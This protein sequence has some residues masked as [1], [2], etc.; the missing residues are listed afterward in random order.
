[1]CVCAWVGGWAGCEK[2]EMKLK[3]GGKQKMRRRCAW[4]DGVSVYYLKVIFFLRRDECHDVHKFCMERKRKNRT[5]FPSLYVH[6]TDE[7]Q[8]VFFDSIL[9][10]VLTRFHPPDSIET[11]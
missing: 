7:I 1:M 3:T 6:E 4:L 11:T 9:L 10:T 8:E 2:R 5:S